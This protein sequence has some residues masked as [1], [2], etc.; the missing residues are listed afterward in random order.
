MPRAGFSLIELVVVLL[1]AGVLAA[2]IVPRVA[3]FGAGPAAEADRLRANL[4]FA[5]A[6]AL[7]NN[8]ADWSVLIGGQFYQL[9][10]NG[11]PAPVNFPGENGPVR[12]LAAGVQVTSGAGLLSLDQMGAPAGTT[13]ITLSDGTRTQTVTMLGFTGLVP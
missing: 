9:Q 1:L 7:A 4:R 6:L 2:V 5:Q 3:N 11:Q 13:T 10:R 12:T 8:T